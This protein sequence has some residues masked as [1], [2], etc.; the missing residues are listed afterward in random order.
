M[1][2]QIDAYNSTTKDRL[3]RLDDALAAHD[4]AKDELLMQEANR[5]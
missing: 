1:S 4:T 3:K 2:R 5:G